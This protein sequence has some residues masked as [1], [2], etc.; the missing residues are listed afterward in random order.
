MKREIGF[1]SGIKGEDWIHPVWGVITGE[2]IF[3]NG[4][5]AYEETAKIILDEIKDKNQRL[6]FGLALT[7]FQWLGNQASLFFSHHIGLMEGA[8]VGKFFVLKQSE[9]Y[10]FNYCHNDCSVIC[11]IVSNSGK[12]KIGYNYCC[13]SCPL[14]I[15]GYGCCEKINS[16]YRVAT[17]NADK[18]LMLAAVELALEWFFENK[19]LTNSGLVQKSHQEWLRLRQILIKKEA[20]FEKNQPEKIE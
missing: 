14:Q 19:I 16:P 2:P 8:G 4:Y 6:L 11:G 15:I 17:H 1:Y 3:L 10:I 13:K 7:Y 20:C 5:H 9:A 12:K 18:K